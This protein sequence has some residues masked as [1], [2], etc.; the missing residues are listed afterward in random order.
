MFCL[1]LLLQRQIT[2]DGIHRALKYRLLVAGHARGLVDQL[3]AAL[4]FF[5]SRSFTPSGCVESNLYV[6]SAF[7]VYALDA[8]D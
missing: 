2:N 6:E 8:P 3:R 5:L 1:P 4:R 7:W